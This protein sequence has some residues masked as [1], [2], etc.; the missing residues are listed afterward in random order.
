MTTGWPFLQMGSF[1]TP[2]NNKTV[3][4]LNEANDAANFALKNEDNVVLT[5]SIPPRSI[6]SFVLK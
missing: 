1:V 5:S 4:L 2:G 6:Q 3:I